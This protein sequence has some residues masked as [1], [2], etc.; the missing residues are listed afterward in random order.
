[1]ILVTWRCVLTLITWTSSKFLR[2]GFRLGACFRHKTV[3]PEL[4]SGHALETEP[5][6]R[7]MEAAPSN[8][9]LHMASV[10]G[11]GLTMPAM[12]FPIPPPPIVPGTGCSS[13]RM[14]QNQFVY[15][16]SDPAYSNGAKRKKCNVSSNPQP[17]FNASTRILRQEY[18]RAKHRWEKDGL[19]VS[20]QILKNCLTLY[21][22]SVKEAK[23]KYFSN[24]ITKNANKPKV[25]FKT[26]HY[27]LSPIFAQFLMS[28]LRHAPNFLNFLLRRTRY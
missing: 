16:S 5:G 10:W 11:S 24:L 18:R 19:Q 3:T 27:F 15:L 7:G 23:T 20:Y 22:I 8:D 2:K 26:I 1:M 13:P 21:Q 6:V 9:E 28:I 17:W 4:R 12:V 14:A 25:L